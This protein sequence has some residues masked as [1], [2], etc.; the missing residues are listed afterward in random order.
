MAHCRGGALA[1]DAL[2]GPMSET[3]NGLDDDCN[4]LVDDGLGSAVCGVGAC[5][6]TVA[7]CAGGIPQ[8][9]VSGPAGTEICGNTLDD[10]CDGSADESPCGPTG[11]NLYVDID[12]A[13]PF[14]CPTG[15]VIRVWGPPGVTVD[16]A[17]GAALDIPIASTWQGV[18]A[19]A[20]LCHDAGGGPD[21]YYS[22]WSTCLAGG[23]CIDHPARE[24][25]VSTI[26]LNGV[27][28]ST[29]AAHVCNDPFGPGAKPLIPMDS[30]F[31]G[32]CP[33]GIDITCDVSSRPGWTVASVDWWSSYMG[34]PAHVV[35]GGSVTSQRLIV[36]QPP[37]NY[38]RASF[39]LVDNLGLAHRSYEDVAAPLCTT[40]LR[41]GTTFDWMTS[42]LPSIPVTFVADPFTPATCP[43][44]AALAT[45]LASGYP[46]L[47][48]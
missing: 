45:E 6:R 29:G 36:G 33:Y 5:S 47:C 44:G 22:G 27:E 3:C 32:S 17:P 24:A 43:R 2:S 35:N 19:I 12:P 7:N 26:L 34:G 37:G 41:F 28:L 38:F 23:S 15:R 13:L 1:C 8:S 46:P 4:G 9:C 30:A 39:N 25:G 18:S 14:P 10:D 16:S 42:S 31:A 20:V 40:T 48:P 21:T 11:G